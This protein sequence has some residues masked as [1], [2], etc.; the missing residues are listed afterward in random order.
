[1]SAPRS[2][3]STEMKQFLLDFNTGKVHDY[4]LTAVEVLLMNDPELH[5]EY[6][7]LRKRKK[8][9]LKFYYI[10]KFNEQNPLYLP[11]KKY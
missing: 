2:T 5:D 3:R 4:D 6:M 7:E 1:M 10:R 9:Q 11:V 8:K